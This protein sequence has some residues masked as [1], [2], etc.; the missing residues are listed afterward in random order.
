MFLLSLGGK[1]HQIDLNPSVALICIKAQTQDNLELLKLC[2]EN[3]LPTASRFCLEEDD[4]TNFEN[5][6]NLLD[7]LEESLEL[8]AAERCLALGEK[9]GEED[10]LEILIDGAACLIQTQQNATTVVQ[11]FLHLSISNVCILNNDTL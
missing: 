10:P 1:L 9:D 7:C 5:V 11:K 8:T 4:L 3:F 2:T 6:K